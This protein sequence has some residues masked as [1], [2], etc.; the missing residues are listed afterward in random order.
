MPA[1]VDDGFIRL[2]APSY[3]LINPEHHHLENLVSQLA[4]LIVLRTIACLM[5][6]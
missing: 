3:R 1:P 2:C 4:T 5:F 6:K